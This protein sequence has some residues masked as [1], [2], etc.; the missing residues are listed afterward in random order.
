[1]IGGGGA[2]STWKGPP[3]PASLHLYVEDV[4]ALYER[5][6][7]AGATSLMG[8]A[9]QEYG[10][11]SAAFLDP[12]GN[13]W[14]PATAVG[15]HYILEGAQNLMPYLHQ[16]GAL[17]QIDFLKIAFGAE[18]IMRHESPDGIIYHAKIKI[19]DSIVEMGEAHDPWLPMPMH[20]MLYVDDADAWYARAMQTEGAIS[21]GA[22][23]NQ[24]YGGRTGSVKDPFDNVWYISG[25]IK[26]AKS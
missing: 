18:E 4:D 20:F 16:R 9:D 23:A 6:L 2:G 5:A 24:G 13:H 8:P 22:P 19:V 1:M 25:P 14:Y 21:M 11:R 15:A 10:E 12:G 26:E 3:M 17:K 7:Q